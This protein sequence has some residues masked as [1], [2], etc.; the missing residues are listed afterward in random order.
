MV[1]IHLVGGENLVVQVPDVSALPRLL[2]DPNA[3]LQVTYD[4]K[5]VLIPVRA[6]A[7]IVQM[8]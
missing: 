5:P 4:G 3:V 1:K 8:G 2:A 7:A 6:V